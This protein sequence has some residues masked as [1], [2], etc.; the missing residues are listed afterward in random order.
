MHQMVSI[1]AHAPTESNNK[2]Q[3][4]CMEWKGAMEQPGLSE[5]PFASHLRRRPR[6]FD[7]PHSPS[8]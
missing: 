6:K 5:W 1:T 3:G 8:L 2:E 4:H 7:A